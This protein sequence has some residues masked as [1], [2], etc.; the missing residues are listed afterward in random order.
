MG[1]VDR[2]WKS[3]GEESYRRVCVGEKIGGERELHRGGER[4]S[5]EKNQNFNF[6]QISK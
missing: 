5:G 6:F 3:K 2:K 1:V 4:K